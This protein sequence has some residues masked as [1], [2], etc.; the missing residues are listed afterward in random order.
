[1][2]GLTPDMSVSAIAPAAASLGSL[3]RKRTL[4]SEGARRLGEKERATGLD[5]DDEAAQWLSEHDPAPP[6]AT[7]KSV[8]KSKH[9][10]RWK[11]Q[12]QRGG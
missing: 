6:P 5:P 3:A 2:R 9:L 12:Q 10:H 7:P 4:T 11:Q 8:G 1:V